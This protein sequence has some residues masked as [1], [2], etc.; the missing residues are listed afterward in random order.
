MD[1]TQPLSLTPTTPQ[2][3][4]SALN[5]MIQALQGGGA[6]Y[7]NSLSPGSVKTPAQTTQTA[8]PS[9]VAPSSTTQNTSSPPYNQFANQATTALLTAL[10][11]SPSAGGSSGG[12]MGNMGGTGGNLGGLY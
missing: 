12:G 11:G 4:N 8:Q 10:L 7:A 2:P 9:G 3:A 6:A 5:N 1:P